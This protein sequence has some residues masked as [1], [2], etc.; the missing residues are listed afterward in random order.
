MAHPVQPE[1]DPLGLTARQ[2]DILTAIR[3][4]VER[5][6]YPPTV[7][8]IG[9]AVGLGSPSSVAHHLKVLQRRGLV[10]RAAHGPRA[11]DARPSPGFATPEGPGL[12]PGVRVPLLGTIAAGAP[13]L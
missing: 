1:P 3:G 6:G 2:R 8:E 11:V 5:H 10:R 4:W 7:R 12:R 9:A 13:I